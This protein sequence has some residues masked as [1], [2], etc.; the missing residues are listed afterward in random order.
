M[1]TKLTAY[2]SPPDRMLMNDKGSYLD[3][4]A[5]THESFAV[6]QVSN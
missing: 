5:K 4:L 1:N 3:P 2:D 6:T